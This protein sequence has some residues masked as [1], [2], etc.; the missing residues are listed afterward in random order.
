MAPPHLTNAA[1]WKVCQ[2][3]K[4]TVPRQPRQPTT[5]VIALRYR[6]TARHYPGTEATPQVIIIHL[7]VRA[8]AVQRHDDSHLPAVHVI[9]SAPLQHML[10]PQTIGMPLTRPQQPPR[11]IIR[12]VPSAYAPYAVLRYLLQQPALRVIIISRRDPIITAQHTLF[13]CRQPACCQSVVMAAV[14]A[15]V[16]KGMGYHRAVAPVTVIQRITVSL[17][18]S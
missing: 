16:V 1:V 5:D 4:K 6:V 10:L 11:H 13:H 3:L 14:T 17:S 12:Q 8:E 2:L 15:A 9:T 18:C 7:A